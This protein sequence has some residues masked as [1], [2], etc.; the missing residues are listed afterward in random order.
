MSISNIKSVT[1]LLLS[2]LVISYIADKLIFISLNAISDKVLSGQSIGKL[3]HY[4]SVKDTMNVLVYGSSRANHQ[5]DVGL[6][7]NK[8]FNMGN[9]GL[10]IA[11]SSIVIK[12]LPK[13][14]EQLVILNLD[15][16]TVF[17][18]NYSGGDINALMSKYHRIDVVAEELDKSDAVNVLQRFYWSIDY[19]NK[20]M[21][22]LKNF[23]TPNYNHKNYNGYDPIVLSETQKEIR[24]KIFSKTISQNCADSIVPNEIVINYLKEIQTFCNSTNKEFLVITTPY[25]N[26]I[27]DEDN[28]ELAKIM[29]KLS[30]N[31][32]DYSNHFKQNNSFT[33]WK[34]KGHLSK[35]GAELF[36][37]NFIEKL[38]TVYDITLDE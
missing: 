19:N 17:D 36:T 3:N 16:S 5:I 25:Y 2:I 35:K 6:I 7:S 14:K 4:L 13:K 10:D 18:K 11:Y 34:D 12:I 23:I 31:Y 29:E 15:P 22:I 26:D 21:G 30:L 37:R 28:I 20:T 32:W 33:L 9:D 27:C 38:K 1:R 24:D 8:S